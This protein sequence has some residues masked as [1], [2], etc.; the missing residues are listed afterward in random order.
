MNKQSPH[1]IGLELSSY[2]LETLFAIRLHAAAITNLTPDHLD[3]YPDARHYYQA[4][5]ALFNL[6]KDNGYAITGWS[7][8]LGSVFS[9]D[10]LLLKV[11][12]DGDSLWLK[13]FGGND[14]EMGYNIINTNDN[15]FLICG[16]TV[17]FGN[18][19]YIY[20]IKTYIF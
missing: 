3:R 17:S 4:K 19:D 15:G 7:N 10:I 14:N 9:K 16:Y 18:D 13:I 12:Q 2:Q 20:L 8:G 1:I 5:N 6:V 11:N